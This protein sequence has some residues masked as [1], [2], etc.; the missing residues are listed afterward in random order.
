[1]DKKSGTLHDHI[2]TDYCYARNKFAI[3]AF[4]CDTQYFYTV[5]S[6]M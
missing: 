1:M 4:L 2:R 5:D 6:D 3:E